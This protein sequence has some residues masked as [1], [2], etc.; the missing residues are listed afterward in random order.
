[1]K[2]ILPTLLLTILLASCQSSKHRMYEA[3]LSLSKVEVP[4]QEKNAATKD[5]V[6][7]KIK[8]S[9]NNF[10]Y[11]SD[12]FTIKWTFTQN[13]F[14]FE[15]KN[16]SNYTIKIPW[17][18]IAFVDYDGLSGRVLHKGIQYKDKDATMPPSIIPSGAHIN[19]FIIPVNNVQYNENEYGSWVVTDL[20]LSH[21]D[22][23][24]D[25]KDQ[26]IGKNV[27]IRMPVII[28]NTEHEYTFVFDIKDIKK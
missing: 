10:E 24:N 4:S 12:F 21:T 27:K 26:Y 9:K 17:N 16:K 15:L 5:S 25:L 20:F 3:M 2:R 13:R 7:N 22:N 23:Y 6:V 19:D 14:E 28:D 18:G 11:V 8:N 1:M